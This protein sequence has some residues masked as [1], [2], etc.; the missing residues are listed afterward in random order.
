MY[1]DWA[2][3]GSIHNVVLKSHFTYG[4]DLNIIIS[5]FVLDLRS[6]KQQQGSK[7]GNL[8]QFSQSIDASS[9]IM[10]RVE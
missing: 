7:V 9:A 3:D 5:S 8:Q 2:G 10:N 4:G 1:V 6:H